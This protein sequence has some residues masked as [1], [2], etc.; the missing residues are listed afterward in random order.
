MTATSSF[1][2]RRTPG[3]SCSTTARTFSRRRGTA[4]SDIRRHHGGGQGAGHRQGGRASS[5]RP[6]RVTRSPSRLRASCVGQRL[7]D[8]RRCGRGDARQPGVH[9]GDPVL[10]RSDQGLLV[11][12]AQDVDTVRAN[13]FAGQSA[14]AIWSTFIL[15]EMAGL[16]NDAK[17]TC[18]ECQADPAF[19]AKNTGVVAAIKGP[20]GEPAQFGEVVSWTVTTAKEEP[21]R[22]SS[23]S[24]SW[25]RATSIGWRSLQK[26]VPGELR[27][28]GEPDRVFDTWKTLRSAWTR[29]N[30]CGDSTRRTSSPCCQQGRNLSRWGITQ[31]QGDLVGASLGELPVPRRSAR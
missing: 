11:S 30:R 10:R 19:L 6:P 7:P 24:T 8:G 31:G 4:P 18:P 26:A 2:S 5:V 3:R 23:S 29:R 28:E 22:R 14:M 13:Y 1:R 25:A 27:H 9:G 21:S 16:R 12:G 17:P 15:D 20:D